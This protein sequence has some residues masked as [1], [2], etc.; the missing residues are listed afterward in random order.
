M[1]KLTRGHR[2]STY[3]ILELLDVDHEHLSITIRHAA[4]IPPQTL[5]LQSADIPAA[6]QMLDAMAQSLVVAENADAASRWTSVSTLTNNSWVAGIMLRELAARGFDSFDHPDLGVSQLR[7]LYHPLSSSQKRSACWLLARIV[8][9]VHPAG[10]ELAYILKN[11][12]FEAEDH[13][14]FTYDIDVA[15]DIEKLGRRLWVDAYVAQRA[16]VAAIGFDVAGR[17][18]LR[19]SADEL[20][21]WATTTYPGIAA[22]GTEPENTET[23]LRKTAWALTH[24]HSFGYRKNAHK[25]LVAGWEMRQIGRALYP[26]NITLVPCVSG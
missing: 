17:D 7:E 25:P 24:P 6:H 22:E 21:N 14:P 13:D 10:R 3:E 9:Q 5:A 4:S 1:S 23:T 18:W 16:L 15:A 12:R 19:L 8:R 20:I 2:T 26:D 11:S